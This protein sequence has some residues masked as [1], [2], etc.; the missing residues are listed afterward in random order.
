[1][2]TFLIVLEYIG[3]FAFSA[4]G[5][6][7]AI[8]KEVDY[9][10]VLLM[11][12]VTCFGGGI[13]R[14]ILL[15]CT[16]PRFFTEFAPFI[17]VCVCTTVVVIIFATVFKRAFINYEKRINDVNNVVDALGL[18][19]FA[20]GGVVISVES[21]FTSPLVAITMGIISSVG[22]GLTRDLILRDIPFI[23]RK[24]IYILASLLGA[25]LYYVLA[26]TLKFDALISCIIGVVS[27]FILR[28]L[29]TIFKWNIP[30]AI[31][32]AKLEA[33]MRKENEASAQNSEENK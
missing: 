25:S 22:G 12:L 13:M 9:I 15:G 24:R 19:A 6:M 10:G 31:D 2:D 4:S 8:D 3:M 30:K 26:V 14:D 32:F 33:I 1:M 29:A 5:A 7:V 18:G 20:V 27:T 16:P 11:S 23:L 21:G 17:I 28:I